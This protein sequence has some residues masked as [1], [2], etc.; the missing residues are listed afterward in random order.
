MNSTT[1]AQIR[2]LTITEREKCNRK[3]NIKGYHVFL[4]R[5]IVDLKRMSV[6]EKTKLLIDEKLRS[7]TATTSC[8]SVS[9]SRKSRLARFCTRDERRSRVLS[10]VSLFS[11]HV[12]KLHTCE[13]R[14]L[15]FLYYFPFFVFILSIIRKVFPMMKDSPCQRT[16]LKKG[17]QNFPR[18]LTR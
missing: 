17:C 9:V 3:K 13:A 15:P 5:F 7:A 1:P 2:T 16:F 4:V 10:E 18:V 8:I 11:S 6:K 12:R 14:H